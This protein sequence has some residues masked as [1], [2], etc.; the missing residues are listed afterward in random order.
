M[1]PQATPTPGGDIPSAAE[2]WMIATDIWH[3]YGR[4]R[5]IKEGWDLFTRDDNRLDIERIDS[6][7]EFR[8]LDG[9]DEPRF[10]GDDEAVKHI[11]KRAGE[12]SKLHLLALY[13]DGRCHTDKVWVHA[14]LIS[15]VPRT[16]DAAGNCKCDRCSSLLDTDGFC[17]DV[18]CPFS[19]HKQ[20]CDAGWAGLLEMDP[21][22]TNDLTG[23]C[24]CGG[25]RKSRIVVTIPVEIQFL[26]DPEELAD[27]ERENE[28]APTDEQ[29]I[30]Y[31]KGPAFLVDVDR[32]SYGELGGV[33]FECSGLHIAGIKI[34]RTPQ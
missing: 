15:E 11:I 28:P 34:E 33:T 22:P 24:S 4:P 20:T 31:V 30:E 23:E 32:E 8:E 25:H 12:G 29:I 6:P 2:N 1:K 21:H 19:D 9:K 27:S 14:S 5:A 16:A 18:A 17:T 26:H 7:C 10:E 13:L 3:K